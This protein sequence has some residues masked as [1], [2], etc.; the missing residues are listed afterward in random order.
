MEWLRGKP[1]VC[2]GVVALSNICS[3]HVHLMWQPLRPQAMTF[4]YFSF[5][6]P[7]RTHEW[8]CAW[9]IF[10][11]SWQWP[12]HVLSTYVRYVGRVAGFSIGKHRKQTQ[13]VPCSK[14]HHVH[15]VTFGCFWRIWREASRTN[16]TAPKSYLVYTQAFQVWFI[17][18]FQCIVQQKGSLSILWGL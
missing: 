1:L 10:C 7:I 14:E 2:F 15:V 12:V 8:R 3:C 6:K 18:I 13:K 11:F 9:T 5:H 4:N 17:S 16:W